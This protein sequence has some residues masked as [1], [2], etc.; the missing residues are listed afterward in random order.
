MSPLRPPFQ[1]F[2]RSWSERQFSTTA[3][4]I[5]IN[6][7][8]FILQLMIG[9]LRP[10]FIENYL[11][12]SRNGV[13][14]GYEWQWVTYMFLHGNLP[15][16]IPGSILHIGFNMLTLM[17]AGREVERV[18]GR[19]HFLGIY[20]AGGILGGIVQVLL[21]DPSTHLVG[22]SAAV[23]AVL[24]A[25]TT[26][27][28]EIQLTLLLFLIIPI[29]LKAKFLALGLVLSSLF[30]ALTDF[31]PGVGHL[32][33]LGGS[34][35]GWI[36]ARQL[37]FGLKLPVPRFYQEKRER[38]ER[39]QS[40]TPEEFISSEIDPILDKISR[41]GIHSLTRA[42]RKILE[43]GREKIELKTNRR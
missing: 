34:F 41:E 1:S 35:S 20:F 9:F 19:R 32:A 28:P 40:M 21:S 6:I 5:G 8:V 25:F 37:G 13:L 7:A 29:R 11:A 3:I 33:H 17:F 10:G 27:Y 39:L 26:I 15:A 4:L 31:W 30:F 12:L 18:V 2:N 38:H 42:E 43:K 14:A 16:D 23:F 24:I 36:Y 22:A